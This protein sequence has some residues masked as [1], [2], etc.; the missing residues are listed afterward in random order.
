MCLLT[1]VY[2]F[3]HFLFLTRRFFFVIHSTVPI[4]FE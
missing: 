2:D 3:F 1:M 4:S